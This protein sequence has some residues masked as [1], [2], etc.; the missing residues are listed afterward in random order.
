MQNSFYAS[1]FLYSLKKH[2]ILLLQS[3]QKNN[4]VSSWS[5]M[6]GEGKDGEE[7]EVTFQRIISKLLNLDLKKK[8][9]YPVYDYFHNTR[10]KINHVFYAEVGNT[11]TFN[12][13]KK[14][15]FS[16]VSFR[17]TLKLPFTSQTKQDIVVGER[18]INAKWRDD[19]A[20]KA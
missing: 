3:P 19:E 8:H 13:S 7:A 1:G 18:V 5:M 16:W 14:G 17:E 9:I 10:N 11:K 4:L 20:K 6:G 2:R 12:S 15:I